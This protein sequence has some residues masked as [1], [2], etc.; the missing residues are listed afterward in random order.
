M[1]PKDSPKKLNGYWSNSTSS[2]EELTKK[3]YFI[4][5]KFISPE[6]K[7]FPMPAFQRKKLDN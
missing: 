1:I 5:K 4:S 7:D 6:A 3:F 2:S